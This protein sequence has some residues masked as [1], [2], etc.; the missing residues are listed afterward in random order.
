MP[1]VAASTDLVLDLG[2]DNRP[3]RERLSGA[4]VRALAQ[5]MLGDGDDMPSTRVLA[6]HLGISRTLVVGVYEELTASG[7]LVATPGGGTTVE[8][9]AQA[10]ARAGAM[11]V[12]ATPTDDPVDEAAQDEPD[13]PLFDMLP[14]YPD[15]SL[16]CHREWRSAW[17]AAGLEAMQSRDGSRGE[18]NDLRTHHFHPRLRR[19]LADHMR[20][21]R[22]IV[23]APEDIFVFPGVNSALRTLGPLLT[24]VGSTFAFEDPGYA[25]ARRVLAGSGH[26]VRAVPV[27]TDGIDVNQLEAG[28]SAVYVTP[29]HQFPLGGRLPVDSRA[30][31][32]DW[33]VTNDAL[34]FEDDY[35]GEFRYDVP[36]MPAIRSMNAGHARVVYLGT[37]SKSI[38]RSL[39]LA[40]AVV[41]EQFRATVRDRLFDEGDSVSSLACSVLSSYIES[42]GLQKHLLAA[43]RTYFARRERLTS[44][45][46]DQLPRLEL[47]GVHAGLHLV[48]RSR[49]DY[50]DDVKVVEGLAGHGLACTA[51]S[52]Y[53]HTPAHATMHGLVLGYSRLPETQAAPAARVMRDVL[54]GGSS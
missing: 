8:V 10:A 3:L 14:G 9:G 32:L 31:L 28:D 42:R 29:A 22:G 30:N 1:R 17:R 25:T 43:Q 41:P 5:G 16:I 45:C 23:C 27:G 40:W 39:R 19:A 20:R 6:A 33:A 21:T 2:A 52:Q 11:A 49:D 35:D 4:L 44:A 12:I 34:V 48:L 53:F 13:G 51:L 36:P 46:R 24:G 7:F 37:A 18:I 54:Y 38:S 47:V 15:T 50:F 26:V